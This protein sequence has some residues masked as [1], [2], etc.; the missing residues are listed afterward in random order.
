MHALFSLFLRADRESAH[1]SEELATRY[2]EIDLLHTIND[3]LGQ[4]LRLEDAANS[5]IREV[6]A[7]V[8]AVGA[9]MAVLDAE[10]ACLRTVAA[11]G[12]GGSGT[13]VIQLDDPHSAA[14]RAVR[15]GEPQIDGGSMSV[16]I[17]YRAPGGAPRCV[18]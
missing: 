8:G 17:T 1:L 13:S 4:T 10:S 12:P 14:A 6:S 16:P 18:G 15:E 2:E 7:V 9:S 3:V 11:L 5:I